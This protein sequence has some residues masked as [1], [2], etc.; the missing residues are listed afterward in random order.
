MSYDPQTHHRRSIRLKN[1][2][3]AQIGA[4]FVTIVVNE[5]LLLLENPAIAAMVQRWWDELPHKFPTVDTDAFVIMPNHIHGIIVIGNTVGADLRVG[6]RAGEHTGSGEHIG[7]PIRKPTLGQIVQWFK[8]MT[9]NEYIRGVKGQGWPPFNRHFWQRNY[10]EH[11]IRN[12]TDLD[13]IRR[14]IAENPIRWEQDTEHPNR[15]K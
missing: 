8:T 10:Y 13:R 2:D 12:E 11:V 9:T 14:Y 3:Y 4:Y 7:S 1:Y 5:R 15:K 6:P